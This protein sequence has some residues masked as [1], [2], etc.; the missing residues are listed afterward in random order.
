MPVLDGGSASGIPTT[1]TVLPV[2]EEIILDVQKQVQDVTG[3]VYSPAYLLPYIN[4]AIVEMIKV[5]P[6]IYPVMK[7][8]SLVAGS[9]QTIDPVEICILDIVCNMIGGVLTG[10]AITILQR[11][12]LDQLIPSW[13]TFAANKTIKYVVKDDL[14]PYAFYVFPPQPIDT[15]QGIKMIF[16]ELPAQLTAE[17]DTFPLEESLKLPC[18]SYILYLILREETTIPNALNKATM[19][20]GQFYRQM[21]VQATQSQAQEQQQQ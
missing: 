5:N 3:T 10:N 9:L 12:N 21:G 15:D 14:D 19:C 13:Q 1:I 17:D 18:I 16:S 4:L 20:L 7:V 2:T 6:T 11:K 8:F